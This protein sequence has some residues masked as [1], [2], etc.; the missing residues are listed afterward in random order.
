MICWTSLHQLSAHPDPVLSTTGCS[1]YDAQTWF[2]DFWYILSVCF[3]IV[4]LSGCLSVCLSIDISLCLFICLFCLSIDISL[5]PFWH[6]GTFLQ[7]EFLLQHTQC[8]TLLRQ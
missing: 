4:C 7:D 8:A 5:H 2:L 3:G 1:L 6:M